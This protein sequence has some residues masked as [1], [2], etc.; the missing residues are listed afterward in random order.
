MRL[1]FLKWL[2]KRYGHKWRAYVAYMALDFPNFMHAGSRVS[3]SECAR[4]GTLDE[5]DGYFR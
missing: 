1:R 4:C 2:C 3:I 5:W